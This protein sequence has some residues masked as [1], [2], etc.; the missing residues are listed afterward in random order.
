[1]LEKIID[2]GFNGSI[3]F[4]KTNKTGDAYHLLDWRCLQNIL[5][6]EGEIKDRLIE[7]TDDNGIGMV[8][9]KEV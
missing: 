4:I 6:A 1:M 8:Y 5:D 9:F 7:I 3:G 2:Y